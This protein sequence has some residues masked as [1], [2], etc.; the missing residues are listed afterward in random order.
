[1]SNFRETFIAA[2]ARAVT[3][4]EKEAML[5]RACVT[6]PESHPRLWKVLEMMVAHRYER[7][8][9]TEMGIGFDWSTIQQWLVANWP[10]ILRFAL[11]IF[12]M[13]L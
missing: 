6:T 8:T 3:P 2:R 5:D 7:E 11:S 1:M 13:F 12:L 9:G 10:T 4:A